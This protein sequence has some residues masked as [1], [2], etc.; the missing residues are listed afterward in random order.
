MHGT[1][2]D[3]AT[4]DAIT[5]GE[6]MSWFRQY[7]PNWN[8]AAAA[9][10]Q[11]FV[12]TLNLLRLTEPFRIDVNAP[13]Y[14][15]LER[16]KKAIRTL[17]DDLPPLVEHGRKLCEI[18]RQNGV[19]FA[20]KRLRAVESLYEAAGG[21]ARGSFLRSSSPRKRDEPWHDAAALIAYHARAVWRCTGQLKTGK[22]PTSPLVGLVERALRRVGEGEHNADAISKALRRYEGI[23]AEIQ[24]DSVPLRQLPGAE[25]S[26]D[27]S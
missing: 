14:L 5:P 4:G 16:V 1:V 22:N 24:I 25:S 13:S 2:P 7:A 23:I 21:A 18:E 27:D 10:L 12:H 26:R 6:V 3:L 20:E 11:P 9:A 19:D 15:R 8:T 17:L